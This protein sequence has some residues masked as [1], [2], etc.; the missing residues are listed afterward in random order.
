MR[1]E[2]ERWQVVVGL[3]RA[4]E[5]P[6]HAAERVLL[7]GTGLEAT[8]RVYPLRHVYTGENVSGEA[9][10]VG[11]P[12]GWE[13][14]AGLG[15]AEH[16]WCSFDEACGEL[17]SSGAREAVRLLE[18]RLPGRRRQLTLERSRSPAVFFLR[19]GTEA[20]ASEAA[21]ILREDGFE[22]RLAADSAGWL[23][24]AEGQVR[25]DSFD[26]A[27][28]ALTDLAAARGGAYEGSRR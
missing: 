7:A 12:R 21:G 4:G 18:G 9:F 11:A 2:D 25:G 26:V 14:A 17:P 6:V 15:A 23:V 10:A 1:S 28:R 24:S 13:P 27:E 3:A 5:S 20:V 19:F 16:R 22:V 8:G